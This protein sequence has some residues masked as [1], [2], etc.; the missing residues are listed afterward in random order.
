MIDV[1]VSNLQAGQPVDADRLAAAVR[2]VM[3]QAGIAQASISLAVV[4]DAHIHE[5]NRAHLDHDY[6]TDVLSFLLGH[7]DAGLEGEIIVS[8]DTAAASAPRFGWT[9]ADELLLYAIHGALHLVG[10]D[11][12]T[13]AAQGDM[14]R[15]EAAILSR[16]G[17][18]PRYT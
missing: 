13:P 10:Y 1:E 15:Q 2:E 7:T 18:T 17:L 16:F 12:L 9:A 14:R 6:A 11:D 4:D 8:A 3:R 5:L